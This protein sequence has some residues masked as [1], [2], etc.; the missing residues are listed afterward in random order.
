M[1]SPEV[2]N[3]LRMLN[4]QK[5]FFSGEIKDTMMVRS[6]KSD[7]ETIFPQVANWISEL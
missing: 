2:K 5:V 7:S 1:K 6:V 4:K 3:N